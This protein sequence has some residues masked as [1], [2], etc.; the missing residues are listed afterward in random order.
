MKLITL[1]VVFLLAHTYFASVDYVVTTKQF[2][3]SKVGHISFPATTFGRGTY[4]TLAFQFATEKANGCILNLGKNGDILNVI[5][6]KN[7]LV[8]QDAS[9]SATLNSNIALNQY[10]SVILQFQNQG[11]SSLLTVFLNGKDVSSSL[12]T[13]TF[14]QFS[15][16]RRENNYGGLCVDYKG[17]KHT[18]GAIYFDEF[19]IIDRK[20]TSDEIEVIANPAIQRPIDDRGVVV[21]Y[22]FN[23]GAGSVAYGR[24]GT[25]SEE[26]YQASLMDNARFTTRIEQNTITCK[27]TGDPHVTTFSGYYFTPT[28]KK[29]YSRLLS[30]PHDG[31]NG[32]FLFQAYHDFGHPS[33]PK[34]VLNRGFTIKYWK[35]MVKI[36]L[37]L[38]IYKRVGRSYEK[39]GKVDRVG[40]MY[41]DYVT[42]ARLLVYAA[43]FARIDIRKQGSTH[44]DV[45]MDASGTMCKGKSYCTDHIEFIEEIDYET[46]TPD[47]NP[48]PL[49]DPPQ[50]EPYNPCEENPELQELAE[51]VCGA[52]LKVGTPQY[53]DCIFDVCATGDPTIPVV[54][55]ECIAL[56]RK[57][58]EEGNEEE[59]NKLPCIDNPCNCI[60]GECVDGECLCFSGYTGRDCSQDVTVMN[61]SLSYPGTFDG[62]FIALASHLININSPVAMDSKTPLQLSSFAVE[63]S[64][65]VYVAA[66]R[67]PEATEDDLKHKYYLYVVG[68]QSSKDTTVTI[69]PI[70]GL[71]H[72]TEGDFKLLSDGATPYTGSVDISPYVPNGLIYKELPTSWCATFSGAGFDQVVVGAGNSLGKLDV[73][74]IPAAHTN[75]FKVCG[76]ALPNPCAQFSDCKSCMEN[77]ECGWCRSNSRCLLGKASGPIEGSSC[78]RWAFTFED[79]ISRRINA[80]FGVP[81]NPRKQDVFLVS[82]AVGT[83]A[84]LPAEITV[85]MGQARSAVFDLAIVSP[86]DGPFFGHFQQNIGSYLVRFQNYANIGISFSTY[87]NSQFNRITVLESY[88]G[89]MVTLPRELPNLATAAVPNGNV[90]NA[91]TSIATDKHP[92][93][94][95]STRHVVF[96]VAAG[97]APTSGIDALRNVLLDKS[98]LPVIG[99]TSDLVSGYRTFVNTLG[100]GSV[101][102]LDA[103]GLNLG[104]AVEESIDIATKSVSLVPRVKGQITEVSDKSIWNIQGL[105]DSMRGRMQFPMSDKKDGELVSELVAP[106]YGKATIESLLTDKPRANSPDVEM[107]Q[108]QSL[109]EN[110]LLRGQI[111]E[112]SGIAMD[113]RDPISIKI[114]GFGDAFTPSLGRGHFYQLPDDIGSITD[115][116]QLV[117]IEVGHVISNVAGKIIYVP[118]LDPNREDPKDFSVSPAIGKNPYT[119]L[120][121]VVI[122][123][124]TESEPKIV[125][126]YISY[127]NKPPTN[128]FVAPQAVENKALVFSLDGSDERGHELIAVVDETP[129]Q[130][131]KNNNKVKVGRLFQYDSTIATTLA[132]VSDIY[133]ELDVETVLGGL[134]SIADGDDVSDSQRRVIFIP[135]RYTNSEHKP[136]S[137]LYQVDPKI[138]YHVRQILGPHD[139][140]DDLPLTSSPSTHAYSVQWVNQPPTVVL[141]VAPAEGDCTYLESCVY[142]QNLG[143]F[144]PYFPDP[145]FLTLGGDDIENTEVS[146]RIEAVQCTAGTFLK[147]S[148]NQDIVAGIAI[149]DI[150]INTW[151]PLLK[152]RPDPFDSGVSVCAIT[153]T[154]YDGDLQSSNAT[155]SIDLNPVNQPPY[156]DTVKVYSY[157]GFAAPAVPVYVGD[158]DD[159]LVSGFVVSCVKSSTAESFTMSLNGV[160]FTDADCAVVSAESPFPIGTFETTTSGYYGMGDVTLSCEGCEV[161]S[162]V[163]LELSFDDGHNGD[164]DIEGFPYKY[165]VIGNNLYINKPGY[166]WKGDDEEN[167]STNYY[168][169]VEE[170]VPTQGNGIP[171]SADINITDVDVGAK[172]IVFRMT[173]ELDP[174][175][176]LY[177]FYFPGFEPEDDLQELGIEILKY[178]TCDMYLVGTLEKMKEALE[179]YVFHCGG[180]G[181]PRKYNV[182]YT[183]DDDGNSGSCDIGIP[184]ECP[185]ISTAVLQFTCR[186]T[187]NT[188]GGLIGGTTAAAAAVGIA[189]AVGAW[190]K[191]KKLRTPAEGPDPWLLDDQNDGVVDNPMYEQRGGEAENPLYEADAVEQ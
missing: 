177:G 6:S 74:K 91:L 127:K 40:D 68:D 111:I 53:D 156:S 60:H 137:D 131:D 104:F 170:I 99:A 65:L 13:R 179:L 115:V 174:N 78:P 20:L 52:K 139:G 97:A 113:P 162:V 168:K 173:C 117:E 175:N 171:V 19:R 30:C 75:S 128:N 89:A 110:A 166:F 5:V 160:T 45:Y 169:A 72:L 183:Y 47:P 109:P 165:N 114:T 56:L 126:I 153:Y 82:G 151:S 44:M 4:L 41:F 164:R 49:S 15:S 93:W 181:K 62:Q 107:E 158:P 38:N 144:S 42:T 71:E 132:S 46:G 159:D 23:E 98:I 2:V 24:P 135:D 88:E 33:H 8:I 176:P 7:K 11:G 28:H 163:D 55:D 142:D 187:T 70:V 25:F 189:A 125:N 77:E 80:E 86:R 64:L 16:A 95:P 118:P 84:T 1:I 186:D 69:D 103:A 27:S 17:N 34:A 90:V 167:K 120:T 18:T 67:D 155:I 87:S 119:T 73:I 122:D 184:N 63:N 10:Y 58:L 154:V 37:D 26:S 180:N 129:F 48:P 9:A 145:V 43:P 112:L 32:Y 51:L 94:R 22:P 190:L 54:D 36:D 21:Y 106:G 116:S 85:D 136:A 105:Q 134:T 178:S 57:Y 149:D 140:E 121:H 161:G 133:R 143:V 146:I 79:T 188:P 148:E 35:D 141:E 66:I 50:S 108:E 61:I 59:A 157:D 124:C 130:F 185:K 83:L 102:S 150:P 138:S 96:I 3:G 81:V 31:D 191:F 76:N 39:L 172:K 100:F 182:T 147:N 123:D 152:Y 14:K 29:S 101:I 92:N 12:S